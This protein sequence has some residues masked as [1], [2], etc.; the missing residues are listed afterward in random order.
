[1][2]ID[3]ALNAAKK[4]NGQDFRSVLEQSCSALEA[5]GNAL[6]LGQDADP[7]Q[8]EAFAASMGKQ[9]KADLRKKRTAL[10]RLGEDAE[11]LR[12]EIETFGLLTAD[13]P[14]A[15]KYVT[16]CCNRLQSTA[17][18]RDMD[19][20]TTEAGLTALR[21]PQAQRSESDDAAIAAFKD[22]FSAVVA[23]CEQEADSLQADIAAK[24]REAERLQLLLESAAA[25]AEH[26]A[27]LESNVVN[28]LA[29]ATE[30]AVVPAPNIAA[31]VQPALA[32]IGDNL[33]K[34]VDATKDT[35]E[36]EKELHSQKDAALADA[37]SKRREMVQKSKA[38]QKEARD[39]KASLKQA[40]SETKARKRAYAEAKQTEA[41]KSATY[42]NDV[43]EAML[44]I[45]EGGANKKKRA[46]LADRVEG[47]LDALSL[48][49][50]VRAN[51]AAALRSDSLDDEG[52]AV[53]ATASAAISTKL[54]EIRGT[55][56]DDIDAAKA[57]F[58]AAQERAGALREDADA[59]S[60]RVEAE[61][62]AVSDQT[63]LIRA[64]EKARSAQ[65]RRLQNAQ[66]TLMSAIER[67]QILAPA[68]AA[69]GLPEAPLPDA[70]MPPSSEESEFVASSASGV[71]AI[72]ESDEDVNQEEAAAPVV[73]E[74]A[75]VEVTVA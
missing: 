27:E 56:Q 19:E 41:A 2:C 67:R 63:A 32:T 73:A 28:M 20:A 9:S 74:V 71:S 51:V 40:V 75:P 62:K 64:A 50:E 55:S 39:A 49:E 69:C 1:M 22:V 66:A 72:T 34:V 61:E 21:I 57:A 25:V 7:S 12:K 30:V 14:L 47:C 16:R 68:E 29:Y 18:D 46:K 3:V 42:W 15:L 52:K 37:H 33:M 59:A 44:S 45:R 53:L 60:M 48:D 24:E 65:G 11:E 6:P 36:Q 70:S 4:V 31:G 5:M 10:K 26:R 8:V 17:T 35:F 58:D 54:T 13:K 38:A 23:K 43:G